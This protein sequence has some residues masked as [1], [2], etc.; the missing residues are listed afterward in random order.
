MKNLLILLMVPAMLYACNTISKK[1]TAANSVADTNQLTTVVIKIDGMTCTGC[2]QTICKA[3]EGLSG[4]SNVTASYKDSIATIRYNPDMLTTDK[5]SSK[6]A[7]V[8]YQVK[9]IQ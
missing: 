8:G 2:E 6:I 1:D 7:E 9:G 4:V 5:I 3:V